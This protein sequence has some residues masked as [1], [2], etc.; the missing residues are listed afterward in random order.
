MTPPDR[1]FD[2]MAHRARPH[3][4]YAP[5]LALA[6]VRGFRCGICQAEFATASELRAHLAAGHL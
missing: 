2:W 3:P 6:A 5:T 4:G 1:V